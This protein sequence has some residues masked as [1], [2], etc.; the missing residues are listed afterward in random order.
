[1]QQQQEARVLEIIHHDH[2]AVS[3]AAEADLLVCDVRLHAI[4][5]G[6]HFAL[7]WPHGL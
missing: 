4:W 5:A 1:M 2:D 3:A 7:D 6:P